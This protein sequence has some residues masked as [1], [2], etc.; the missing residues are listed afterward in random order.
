MPLSFYESRAFLM[1]GIKVGHKPGKSTADIICTHRVCCLQ[2]SAFCGALNIIL[3]KFYRTKSL[4]AIE[5]PGKQ[6]SVSSTSQFRWMNQPN[7]TAAA[8]AIAMGISV[9]AE[10]SN[11]VEQQP[12]FFEA[13]IIHSSAGFRMFYCGSEIAMSL[14]TNSVRKTLLLIL[15]S[16]FD[17]QLCIAPCRLPAVLTIQQG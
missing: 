2:I 9:L 3:S 13:S 15:P 12:F 6:G 14:A 4:S 10:T 16:R 8:V 1:S 7:Y 5:T 11:S 17:G